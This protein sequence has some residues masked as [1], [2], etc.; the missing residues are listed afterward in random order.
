ML[1]EVRG[2]GRRLNG[3]KLQRWKS[4]GSDLQVSQHVDSQG[5]VR[6]RLFA[7]N[8]QT[9]EVWR[10]DRAVDVAVKVRS[11]DP[12]GGDGEQDARGIA[13]KLVMTAGC[14]DVDGGGSRLSRWCAGEL[15]GATAGRDG[16][17]RGERAVEC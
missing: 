13:V 5:A 17:G 7:A 10:R 15:C 3:E 11:S 16:S 9:R 1:E 14:R 6:G 8:T 4:T 12:A 2:E